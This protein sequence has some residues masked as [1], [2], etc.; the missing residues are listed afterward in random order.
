M[1]PFEDLTYR[2][3]A[4]RL[5]ALAIQA[6]TRYN[7][8]VTR[9]QLVSNWTNAIFRVRTTGRASYIIRVCMPG[10]RTDT[11]LRSEIMWLR[12]LDRDTDIGVPKPEPA[13]NGHYIVTARTLGVLKSCRCMV[14]SWLPGVIL[15]SRLTEENLYRM[16]A[17][18][19]QLHDHGAAFSPP[20]GFTQRKM[21]SIY[22]RGETDILFEDT[23]REA[24]TR[25]TRK[26]FER[27]L[28]KVHDAFT[29]R[30]ADPSGLCVIHNDLHHE[31]IKIYRGHLYPFDFEDTVWEYPVQDIA[32]AL[33]DLMV[34]VGPEAFDPL[35]LAFREG[36]E[37]SGIWPADNW[38]EIDTFRAGRM[39]W[40]TNYVA[41]YER[42][43]LRKHIDKL[44]RCF[45][46]F[47]ET[48]MIRKPR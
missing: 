14:M 30:Y 46:F 45:E 1:R 37:S 35:Q 3:R 11:D 40:V 23:C 41:C 12:A 42:Q 9:V 31:N 36:Y 48:G 6:L 21:D 5:R 39:I 16:G 29:R 34:D 19:A 47:L 17:L 32:M 27:T 26:I 25:H 38:E 18:F 10:W 20:G 43:Y 7:L 13:R 24:F 15:G 4:N 2:G 22:A 28:E 8:N 44:S 33:Q